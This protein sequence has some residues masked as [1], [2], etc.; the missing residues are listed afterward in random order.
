MS[1]YTFS[2]RTD[3]PRNVLYIDQHGRPTADDFLDL[4]R[5]FLVHAGELQ[6]GFSIINDQ[7]GMEPYDDEAMEMAKDLVETTSRHGVSR[8]IRI[9]PSD[10][11]STVQISS[12]LHK[13]RSRY[14]SI[15]VAS[16]EEAEEAL[17]TFLR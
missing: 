1:T 8:V 4:K 2:M 15:R 17:E 6:T 3:I 11:L 12:S 5:D 9:V 16:P 14:P 7:R 13:G 10:F